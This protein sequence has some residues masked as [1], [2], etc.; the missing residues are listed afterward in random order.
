MMTPPLCCEFLRGCCA[1]DAPTC[2]YRHEQQ[3]HGN[4]ACQYVE[5]GEHGHR[6]VA[7]SITG[8][9]DGTVAGPVPASPRDQ[10]SFLGAVLLAVASLAVAVA[11]LTAVDAVPLGSAVVAARSALSASFTT[12]VAASLAVVAA[13]AVSIVR[14][15]ASSKQQ[16]QQPHSVDD[17]DGDGATV[18][19]LGPSLAG[20]CTLRAER[21]TGK[22][23]M[24]HSE[25]GHGAYGRVY[26]ATDADN[27]AWAVKRVCKDHSRLQAVKDKE[28]LMRDAA[29]MR[30]VRHPNV[31]P[32]RE[33]LDTGDALCY[34]L[35]LAT[36]QKSLISLV[37]MDLHGKVTR[38][39]EP[40][41]RRYF[42]QLR[43]ALRCCHAHGV[44]HR[45]VKPDN[46]LLTLDGRVLLAD[47]G[48]A[49][50]Q[51]GERGSA[52]LST[53]NVGTW[54][55]KPPEFY[56]PTDGQRFDGFAMDAFSAGVVVL[57]LLT[58]KFPRRDAQHRVPLDGEWFH[59]LRISPEARTLLRGLLD[60]DWRRRLEYWR[61]LRDPATHESHPWCDD[62]AEEEKTEEEDDDD[63]T[64]PA[65][66][67]APDLMTD[68][69]VDEV[70]APALDGAHDK[71]SLA[72]TLLLRGMPGLR[73]AR[74]VATT[75]EAD[76][77]P[78]PGDA[79]SVLQLTVDLGAVEC[80]VTCTAAFDGNGCSVLLLD[81][82]IEL[83]SDHCLGE[84]HQ[85]MAPLLARVPAASLS[86]A[87]A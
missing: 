51:G 72:A 66:L 52:S 1:A 73:A 22:A 10:R 35:E 53:R 81:A 59:G 23:Y 74:V 24:L 75:Q 57:V 30:A 54:R 58:G 16:Q 14:P 28:R 38:V 77:H 68:G 25:L 33:T 86:D 2:P 44:A 36:A 13:V 20:G 7:A 85:R 11:I 76:A 9:N 82:P 65:R 78:A 45:D 49:Q 60:E 46:I 31:L 42:R 27:Q 18:V 21:S 69:I 3:G 71:L 50:W 37:D 39:P 26:Y 67:E 15:P 34:V 63:V 64:P 48:V 87:D 19:T 80:D 8:T 40:D 6:A 4:T 12:I 41:V 56:C 84:I 61:H 43:S 47:F 83:V 32:L 62:E 79:C 70:P 5:C 17:G 55:Y 29:T